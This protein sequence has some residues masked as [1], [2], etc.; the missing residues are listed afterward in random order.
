[1]L[2]LSVFEKGS[3]PRYN[4]ISV[5]TH[6]WKTHYQTCNHAKVYCGVCLRPGSHRPCQ[7]LDIQAHLHENTGYH[8]DTL[9]LPQLSECMSCSKSQQC[10]ILQENHTVSDI[11]IL[12]IPLSS[13]LL[14]LV[15]LLLVLNV[16]V[17]KTVV[18]MTTNRTFLTSK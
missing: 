16:A 18:F 14:H 5:P 10:G 9:Y 8:R 2:Q 17:L 7:H 12:L 6:L 4:S 13:K 11:S 3:L 1:M 15:R